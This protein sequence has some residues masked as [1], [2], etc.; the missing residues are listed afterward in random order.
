M[1][2]HRVSP[3]IDAHRGSVVRYVGPQLG[4]ED[5]RASRPSARNI[6]R[7]HL[8]WAR[9]VPVE[10]ERRESPIGVIWRGRVGLITVHRIGIPRVGLRAGIIDPIATTDYGFLF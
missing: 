9:L 3:G 7:C 10:I 6:L 5:N 2:R 1:P 8:S 4:R